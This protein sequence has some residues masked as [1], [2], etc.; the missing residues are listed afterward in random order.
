MRNSIKSLFAES[1]KALDETIRN[2]T[3]EKDKRKLKIEAFLEDEHKGD[4]VIV[5]D[6]MTV[7]ETI[8]GIYQA[9]SKGEFLVKYFKRNYRNIVFSIHLI[10]EDCILEYVSEE[11]RRTDIST[12]KQKRLL[13]SEIDVYFLYYD[14]S[15]STK[16]LS[17][18]ILY[19]LRHYEIR[20]KKL[21]NWK[22]NIYI[23]NENALSLI[24][25]KL[26]GKDFFVYFKQLGFTEFLMTSCFVKKVFEEI[27]KCFTLEY[28]MDLFRKVYGTDSSKSKIENFKNQLPLVL[29]SVVKDVDE[30]N[31]IKRKNYIEDIKCTVYEL[32][33]DPRI[34]SK[35]M[36]RKW[37]MVDNKTKRIFIRWVSQYDLNLFFK[38][39]DATAQDGM[40]RAREFFWGQ[41]V[42]K[43][44]RTW[45]ALGSESEILVNSMT[46]GETLSYGKLKNGV[47]KDQSCFIC[48]IGDY[49]YI[50]WSHNGMLRVWHKSAC[51]FDIGDEFISGNAVRNSSS[52]IEEWRHLGDW[53]SKVARFIR[54]H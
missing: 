9:Y 13:K 47:T 14:E 30:S 12:I 43:M 29:N 53:Q 10:K 50:E 31:S 4:K 21:L 49:I 6:A 2:S 33:G 18:D 17:K 40:W 34:R 3:S 45:V 54:T 11:I 27:F 37:E 1:K 16:I 24:R 35:K 44:K 36:Y 38:I 32:L 20:D 52:K 51:P 19:K 42:P 15:K 26:N 5:P 48:E 8:Y 39:I 46:K 23:F 25:N 22:E 7:E 41:Y 28:R